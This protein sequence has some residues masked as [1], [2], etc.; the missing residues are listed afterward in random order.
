[1]LERI[2]DDERFF[3]GWHLASDILRDGTPLPADGETLVYNGDLKLDQSG[4]HWSPYVVGA[5]RYGRGRHLCRVALGGDTIF[6]EVEEP[7]NFYHF[8]KNAS[9]KRTII[10]RVDVI[11]ALDFFVRNGVVS[12]FPRWGLKMIPD[13][14]VQI[15]EN[16]DE[17]KYKEAIELLPKIDNL[18]IIINSYEMVRYTKEVLEATHKYL[19]RYEWSPFSDEENIPPQVRQGMCIAGAEWSIIY[20]EYYYSLMEYMKWDLSQAVSQEI[21][22]DLQ[23]RVIMGM[24]EAI[25]RLV[26]RHARKTGVLDQGS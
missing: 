8:L 6:G 22:D 14:L 2:E 17:S 11:D 5:L 26:M 18:D 3:Y 16:G 12:F 1:M 19:T 7:K 25:T 13:R 20:A 24:N 10:W 4:L 21:K 23:K 9:R 15:I